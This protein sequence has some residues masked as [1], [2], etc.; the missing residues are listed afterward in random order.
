MGPV[1]V[2]VAGGGK[3][4]RPFD[5]PWY[6][7]ANYF[8]TI[9]VTPNRGTSIGPAGQAADL[10]D[11]PVAALVRLELEFKTL[12]AAGAEV[13][14]HDFPVAGGRPAEP[15]R[16]LGL[17]DAGAQNAPAGDAYRFARVRLDP[18]LDLYRPGV[19]RQV[20]ALLWPHLHTRVPFDAAAD[21]PRP[22]LAQGPGWVGVWGATGVAVAYQPAEDGDGATAGL[23]DRFGE[24]TA[25]VREAEAVIRA[26]SKPAVLVPAGTEAAE[27]EARDRDRLHDL[28]GRVRGIRHELAT[29]QSKLLAEFYQA[30]NLCDILEGIANTRHAV[31][32]QEFAAA[33]LEHTKAQLEHTK[34]MEK[35]QKKLKY[36]EVFLISVYAVEAAH[37]IGQAFDFPH[38]YVGWWLVAAAVLA[39]LLSANYLLQ[40]KRWWLPGVWKWLREKAGHLVLVVVVLAALF[41]AGGFVAKELMGPPPIPP[42]AH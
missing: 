25:I 14:A 28:L 4:V 40:P 32:Q 9:V 37:L 36:V 1:G 31:A 29:P 2:R 13:E 5:D 41:L 22:C 6:D 19:A 33:Q 10:T 20:G 17:A 42:A 30:S 3:H 26:A 7:G 8:C 11:D 39:G 38:R 27:A 35:V 21:G 34:E 23:R 12:F 24:L 15:P 18:D 16:R